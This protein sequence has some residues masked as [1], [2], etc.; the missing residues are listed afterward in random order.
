M[1]TEKP[2]FRNNSAKGG[3]KSHRVRA[4]GNSGKEDRPL[5]TRLRL[6]QNGGGFLLERGANIR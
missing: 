3:K 2:L 5:G 4:A 6:F 1:H